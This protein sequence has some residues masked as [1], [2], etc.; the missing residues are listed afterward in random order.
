MK[1]PAKSA[2]TLRFGVFEFD[3]Q[4]KELHKQGVKIKLQG[5]PLEILAM[6]LER[7]GAVVT[8]EELQ[9]QLWP[10]D[11]FVEFE[12]SLN[13]AVMRLREALGDSADSPHFVETLPRRGYR[14]ITPVAVAAYEESVFRRIVVP[15]WKW[16]VPATVAGMVVAGFFVFQ[17]HRAP[18][19]TESDHIL[20][21]DFD[22]KTGDAVFD[23]TLKQALA[24]K[25]EES[26]FLNILSERHMRETLRL[27]SR[28]PDDPV[29]G[30]IA[31]EICQRQGIKA[32]VTGEIAA[33]G[34][35]FVVTLNALNCLTGDSLG[36]EQ[37]EAVNKEEVLGAL[38]QATTRLRR[39]L[40]E[41]LSSVQT[42]DSPLVEVTTMSLEALK[43]YSL[44]RQRIR[45]TGSPRE[46]V[47][48]YKRAIELDPNFATAY[49]SLG[50]MY[51]GLGEREA[52]I[53]NI[54]KAF[55]LRERLSEPERLRIM[56]RYYRDLTGE[57][58]KAIETFEVWKQMYPRDY[59][60]RNSLGL[61]YLRAG[62]LEKALEEFRQSVRLD[63]NSGFMDNVGVALAKMNRF[64]EAKAFLEDLHRQNRSTPDVSRYLYMIAFAQ[65]DTA[66]MER[67]SE[68]LK[69]KGLEFDLLRLW[70]ATSAFSGMLS[71]ARRYSRQAVDLG[72]RANRKEP[73]ADEA[74][75][76]AVR[77]AA[78]GNHAEAR[79]QASAVLAI[80]RGR[81]NLGQRA[82]ALALSGD[83][84]KAEA[85]AAE[86]DRRFPLD[87]VIQAVSLPTIRAA[88]A[89][90]KND[91][92]RAIELLDSAR[93]YERGFFAPIYVRG[94]AY[95]HA[96]AGKEA[97]AEF[98][99]I[100]DHRGVEPVSFL[101]PLAQLG[102]ARAHAMAGEKAKA[103]KAYEDF[104][105]LWKNADPD[106]PALKEAKA[107][108]EK[109]K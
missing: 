33:L 11:T 68:E 47:P 74:A 71:Q 21:A 55:E 87:T 92:A 88:I 54:R 67:Q 60:P 73:A 105:T 26:P 90:R 2:Q 30:A 100:L 48:F 45:A 72:L 35:R 82:L 53:E 32:M 96:S 43:A 104:F 59:S 6:L 108:Y 77:E 79:K 83:I 51:M 25:L 102:L 12:H 17:F 106:V 62:Q 38:G 58:P 93:L 14:F 81:A 49:A 91:F 80:T 99:K 94:E 23:G 84:A 16:L 27:M 10:G 44:G 34:R 19:L 97:A 85:L 31:Q 36:R 28:S 107:E 61:T 76:T 56:S 50:S 75:A 63:P 40:G 101:Y 103:R 15:R 5:Q 1:V 37:V 95:L 3:R 39:K 18:A 89:L 66:A 98:Q 70:S 29:T 69:A 8:R 20:L 42:F 46:A 78:F 24:V 109:L 57:L 7:T 4:A 65:G 41:S 86:L 13:A 22:N 52:A 9:K 64:A